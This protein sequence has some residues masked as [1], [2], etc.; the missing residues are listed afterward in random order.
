[1]VESI[2]RIRNQ[3]LKFAK[4]VDVINPVFNQIGN[5]STCFLREETDDYICHSFIKIMEK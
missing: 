5:I 4:L 1:M 2:L 3:S